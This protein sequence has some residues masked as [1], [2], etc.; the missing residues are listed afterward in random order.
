VA[1]HEEAVERGVKRVRRP[2]DPAVELGALG[3]AHRRREPSFGERVCHPQQDRAGLVELDVAGEERR[4]EA[5]GRDVAEG[6][7]GPVLA[8]DEHELVLGARLLEGAVRGERRAAGDL[9]QLDHAGD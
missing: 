2:H 3:R 9:E 1:R 6:C 7:V 5:G 4:H 8:V